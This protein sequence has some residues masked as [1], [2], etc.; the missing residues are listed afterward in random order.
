MNTDVFSSD[1]RVVSNANADIEDVQDGSIYKELFSS[2]H[3]YWFNKNEAFTFSFNTDGISPC[4]KS[5]TTIWPIFIVI[6]EIPVEK[7]FC[8]DNI[9]IAGFKQFLHLIIL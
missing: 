6:N 9:I 7:R 4:E 8:L 2:E 5:N 1:S 3:A